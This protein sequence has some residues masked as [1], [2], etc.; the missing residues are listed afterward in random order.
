MVEEICS[1]LESMYMGTEYS[2]IIKQVSFKSVHT[3]NTVGE[4]HRLLSLEIC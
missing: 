1:V 2:K 3:V 4:L